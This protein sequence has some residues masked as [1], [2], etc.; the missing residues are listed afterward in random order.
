MYFCHSHNFKYFM[1][2]SNMSS[3]LTSSSGQLGW[4]LSSESGR[5]TILNGRFRHEGFG[6]HWEIFL[7]WWLLLG[8]L[9]WSLYTSHWGNGKHC[10]CHAQ[11]RKNGPQLKPKY[12]RRLVRQM[13]AVQFLKIC[14]TSYVLTWRTSFKV[15][16]VLGHVGKDAKPVWDPQSHHVLCI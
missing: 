2:S 6:N 7:L 14:E 13:L 3:D 4:R 10:E 1:M 15:V 5:W 16:V 9:C 12:V 11:E 8:A